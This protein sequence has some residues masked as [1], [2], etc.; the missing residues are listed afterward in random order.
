MSVSSERELGLAVV[1]FGTRAKLG[2]MALIKSKKRV[3]DHGEVFTPDWM[4]EAMLDLV[5]DETHRIDARFLEPACGDGRFLVPVL[6]RKLDVVRSKYGRS[7]FDM[8]N[9]ALLGLMC[10][11]GIELLADNVEACRQNLVDLF[12]EHL[13]ISGCDDLYQAALAVLDANIIH[14]DALAM[15]SAEKQPIIF[16]EWGYLG[17]GKFQRRDFRYDALATASSFSAE[18]SLFSQLG[19]HEVFAPSKEYRPMTI[20]KLAAEWRGSPKE[21]A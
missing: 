10:V 8:Q 11:Y 1:P 6:D 3:S 2:K 13:G 9:Y 16:P 4:V 18:G 15:Q 21:A 7:L 5:K 14:G 17:Q 12:S 19:K 20:A